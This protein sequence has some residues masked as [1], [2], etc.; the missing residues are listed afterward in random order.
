MIKTSLVFFIYCSYIYFYLHSYCHVMSGSSIESNDFI[1]K[2]FHSLEDDKNFAPDGTSVILGRPNDV[3]QCEEEIEVGNADDSLLQPTISNQEVHRSNNQ[4][5]GVAMH[6]SISSGKVASFPDMDPGMCT[7]DLEL[8][9][10]VVPKE[11]VANT[12]PTG[13]GTDHIHEHVDGKPFVCLSVFN[14]LHF[15]I[16]KCFI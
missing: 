5:E 11:T 16:F 6:A 7:K 2:P 14:I 3:S 8:D 1:E 4:L 9:N 15:I 12:P 13:L 10:V